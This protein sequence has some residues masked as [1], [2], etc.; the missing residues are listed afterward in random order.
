MSALKAAT[1]PFPVV[2]INRDVN[3]FNMLGLPRI[4][5][6]QHFARALSSDAPLTYIAARSGRMEYQGEDGMG[7]MNAES[8]MVRV[9]AHDDFAPVQSDVRA[10][11]ALNSTLR[12]AVERLQRF[13]PEIHARHAADLPRVAMAQKM[14]FIHG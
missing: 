9:L 7:A 11:C 8:V 10:A 4:S 14:R 2:V 6:E 1:L 12:C 13:Y 3:K 5:D